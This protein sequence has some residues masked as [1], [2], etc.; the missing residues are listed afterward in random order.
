MDREGHV[1]SQVIPWCGNS[2]TDSK[3]SRS[4]VSAIIPSKLAYIRDYRV[5]DVHQKKPSSL[6]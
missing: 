5:T 1:M 6:L 3:Y 2:P 4:V